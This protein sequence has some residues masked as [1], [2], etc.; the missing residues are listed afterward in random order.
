MQFITLKGNPG[1]MV[2]INITT[3][4]TFFF[5]FRLKPAEILFLKDYEQVMKPVAQALNILQGETNHSN[6]YMGY[7][8][9]TITILR[10]K[11]SK[12][13]DIPAMK[14]LVQAL[15]NGINRRIETILDDRKIIAAAILHPK[16]KED[17]TMDNDVIEKGKA[18]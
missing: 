18:C 1:F 13:L 16:F 10:D 9:P 15:L 8:A 14:P 5:Y 6:A 17:W 7:L 11:L 4:P 2:L 12:K 3:R